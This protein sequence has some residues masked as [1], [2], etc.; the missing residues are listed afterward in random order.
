MCCQTKVIRI[1]LICCYLELDDIVGIA[2]RRVSPLRTS[3]VIGDAIVR[4][5]AAAAARLR[6]DYHRCRKV[7]R[8]RDRVGV[9]DRRGT[10]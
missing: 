7:R 5:D 8:V 10:F 2:G 4:S 1:T 9:V 3:D 6:A